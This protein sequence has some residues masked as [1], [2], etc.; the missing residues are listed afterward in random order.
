MD[1][2]S[3]RDRASDI[4]IIGAS[5][6]FPGA[7]T[8][9]KYWE[10]LK[11]GHEA[12]RDFSTLDPSYIK[13]LKN[14]HGSSFMLANTR[15]RDVA[16]FD[17]AFFEMSRREAE[18]MDPQHR[19]FLECA[20]EALETAGY[21]PLEYPGL[22]GMYAGIYANYYLLLHV[23]P[24]LSKQD[25]ISEIQTMIMNEK[26]H[27]TTY[28][29]YKFNLRGPVITVQTACSTSMVAVHLACESLL[30]YSSDIVI[31]GGS[32]V[33]FPQL[34][35]Y[36]LSE[37]GLLSKDGHCRAFDAKASGT[38]Y[39]DGVGVI[40][41]KRYLDAIADGDSIYSVIN[42]T[43]LS[44]DGSA[45][46]G[47]TAPGVKGQID[48]ISRAQKIAEV[49]PEEISYVEAHGT[50]TPLGD[51]IELEA[52]HEVF[53]TQTSKKAFCALGSVKPNIGHLGPASGISSLIK[54]TLALQNKQLPPQINYEEAAEQLSQT[55]SPFYVNSFLSDWNTDRP[56]RKAGISCFGLGGTN[57]HAIVEE[58]P[59]VKSEPGKRQYKL[60]ILSAKTDTALESQR[61][62]LCDF[63]I[64]NP[65]VD[66]DDMAYTLQ[67]GRCGFDHKI[68]CLAKDN[69]E[70]LATLNDYSKLLR[71]HKPFSKKSL[72]YL[73]TD[74]KTI[75]AKTIKAHYADEPLFRKEL[76]K[77][78]ANCKPLKGITAHKILETALNSPLNE[79]LI[80][81]VVQVASARVWEA[82]GL[83]PAVLVGNGLG[84]LAAAVFS[85][86]MDFDTAAQLLEDNTVYSKLNPSTY[87]LYSPKYNKILTSEETVSSHYWC[88]SGN[89]KLDF[90]LFKNALNSNHHIIHIGFQMDN[91]ANGS[92]GGFYRDMALVAFEGINVSWKNY[93]QDEFRKR[94]PLPTYPF[95][96][97][98]FIIEPQNS[99]APSQKDDYSILSYTYL[100]DKQLKRYVA[101]R[102][103]IESSIVK[104]WEDELGIKPVGVC[105]NFFELGGNSLLGLKVHD[106][107]CKYFE[108]SFEV[109]E[110]FENQTIE[111]ISQ[112]LTTKYQVNASIK[113]SSEL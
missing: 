37:G 88:Q 36:Y 113:E 23:F 82:L 32:T 39:S 85:N 13:E 55:D 112:L 106:R 28:A 35:G 34:H 29:A 107:L 104:I 46:V 27:L 57:V 58:A 47:Y 3:L 44:N 69:K 67:I 65:H 73:F 40:V 64:Q 8:L 45:R 33:S 83:K 22:M 75:E 111:S 10:N 1:Y 94:I 25:A 91:N 17:A 11:N 100:D 21:N 96:K 80:A 16:Y 105:D 86:V 51:K 41:L 92:D 7:D 14:T 12:I 15:L 87:E 20:W 110:F 50:G 2:N 9:G 63:L 95:E 103:N 66:L 77:C 54:T 102:N 26:D 56:T 48:A 109:Q 90:E 53:K 68:I 6:R 101:P 72:I 19:I 31:A 38:I 60:I 42:G 5:L 98:K 74:Q 49:H 84:H 43:A 4:A 78:L 61:K 71:G 24:S 70:L 52:L 93:Y 30:T 62:R 76:E 59:E 89:F 18:L 99:S 97:L 81:L 79:K 108:T